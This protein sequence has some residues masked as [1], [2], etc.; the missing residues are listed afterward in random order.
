MIK[1]STTPKL[2]WPRLTDKPS[3]N[4]NNLHN[5]RLLSV[6]LGCLINHIIYS[7]AIAANDVE[8]AGDILQIVIP[9]IAYGATHYLDDD[10]GREQFYK[11]FA[12]TILIT[13]GLKNSIYKKRPNGSDKSFPSGHTSAAFQGASFI[14]ERYGFSYAI[15]AYFGAAYV[16]YSRVESDKHYIEDVIAGA[17]IGILSNI[18]FT[19]PHKGFVIKPSANN[20]IYGLTITKNF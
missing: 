14:H 4:D 16:G 18:Y 1:I 6:L 3:P 13:Q 19:T 15:A 8:K 12:V 5:I 9:S 20:K 17:A 11:S 7:N 10:E 2:I